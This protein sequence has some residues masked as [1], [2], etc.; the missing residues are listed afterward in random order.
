MSPMR[1][2]KADSVPPVGTIRRF[3]RKKKK[4]SH[5]NNFFSNLPLKKLITIPHSP[6]HLYFIAFKVF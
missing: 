5:P 1:D 2:P 4:T 3:H 6:I